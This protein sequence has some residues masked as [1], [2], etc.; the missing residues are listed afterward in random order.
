MDLIFVG[1]APLVKQY[2]APSFYEFYLILLKCFKFVSFFRN[3]LILPHS[4]E[5]F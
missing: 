4:S 1:R 3:V 2:L 5:M